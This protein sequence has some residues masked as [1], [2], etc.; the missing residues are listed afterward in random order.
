ME[1][2]RSLLAAFDRASVPVMPLKGPALGEALYRDPGLRPFTDLDLLVRRADV[3]RAVRL[4]ST[5]G[6]RALEHQRPLAY[7]L[8]DATAACFVA[9][10]RG[11]GTL[12]VD[13]HWGLV[14]FPGGIGPRALDTE[15]VWGRAV[16]EERWGRQVLALGR[17]DLV[18]YLALH[19]AIHHP[20]DGLAWQL[21]VALLLRR[22]GAAM[23]WERAIGRAR[24]WRVAGAFY[25]ALSRV[26]R[27]FAACVP[28]AVLAA[29]RPRGAR[30]AI[31]DRLGARSDRLGRFD[32][33][34]PLLLLDR[35]ADLA[36]GLTAGVLPAP[37]WVRRRYGT[38]SALYGYVM[39]YGRLGGIA[40]RML[41]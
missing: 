5:L 17:E 41:H 22:D 29:L 14:G 6:Y 33:L 40:A 12:P 26:E 7:E 1:Q 38:G 34:I 37:A 28:P 8:A 19:L 18:L 9:V 20:L 13:L 30:G 36:R 4:L 27:R 11:S 23:D 3:P 31:L 21:D 32:H 35:G 2:L 25:F 16:T 15:E 39:H 10:E 24:R